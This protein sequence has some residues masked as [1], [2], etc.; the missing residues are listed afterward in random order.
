MATSSIS[1]TIPKDAN[2]PNLKEVSLSQMRCEIADLFAPGEEAVQC[3]QTIRDQVIF[4][5]KRV[6]IVNVQ[7]V[8]GKKV[9]YFSYP[10]SKVQYFGIETA[11][12]LDVDSELLLVFNDGNQLQFDFRSRVDVK[13]ICANIS[14]YIL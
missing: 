3:F 11:G 12:I 5:N 4:T 10:Y 14:A 8:T 1:C 2:Y 6:F 13:R 7:G 9:S